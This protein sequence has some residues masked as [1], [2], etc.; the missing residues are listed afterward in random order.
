MKGQLWERLCEESKFLLFMWVFE[1]I[2]GPFKFF[3][4]VS[5]IWCG[6][7]SGSKNP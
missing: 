3:T 7:I 5:E 4:Y 6:F 2:Y 1:S